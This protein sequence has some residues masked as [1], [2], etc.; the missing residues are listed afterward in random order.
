MTTT[1]KT[2]HAEQEAEAQYESIA[3]LVA[4]M[5]ADRDRLEELREERDTWVE[6]DGGDEDEQSRTE[7]EWAKEFPDEA[8]ELAELVAAITI[9]G[10]EID[11]EQASE[12]IQE[13]PL[14][15]RV[16]SDWASPGETMTPGEYEILL[17]TGGPACRI[18]G[19]LDD[20]GEPTRAR[21]E[22]QDWGTP[23]TEWFGGPDRSYS[24]VAAVLLTYARQF[25]Y[26]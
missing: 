1:T 5:E 15:I 9:E 19:D 8:T 10:E 23:W 6:N 2:N 25:C 7:E 12:R 26:Q 11:E 13:D 3:E 18:V 20:H 22:Y 21:I 16:R 24:N 4:A 17:C 14:S